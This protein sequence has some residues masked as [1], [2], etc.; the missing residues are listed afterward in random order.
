MIWSH[1]F[2]RSGAKGILLVFIKQSENISDRML[3]SPP[4]IS[5]QVYG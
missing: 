5:S 1:L 4:I 3:F 2:F